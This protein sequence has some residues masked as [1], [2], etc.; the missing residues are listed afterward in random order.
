MNATARV[1]AGCLTL[2]LVVAACG[3]DNT[4]ETSDAGDSTGTGAPA[5]GDGAG[6]PGSDRADE[7]TSS[8]RADDSD[9][10]TADVGDSTL[11]PPIGGGG[12]GQA[13]GTIEVTITHPE[14]DPLSYTIGCLGD[15]FPVTPEVE[16]VDGGAA[17]ERLADPAVIDRLVNGAPVDQ[18]CTEIYGGPDVATITGELDGQVIDATIDRSNGCGISDWDELLAGV[19][20]PARGVS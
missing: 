8:G 12:E 6:A 3:D 19:L 5:G 10:D 1:L 11:A 4:T 13:I 18:V 14:A 9:S 16:G 15:A 2:G 7:P 20:P 17:C